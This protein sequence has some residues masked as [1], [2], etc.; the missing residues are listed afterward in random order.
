[1]K[2]FLVLLRSFLVGVRSGM[3]SGLGM[4][5]QICVGVNIDGLKGQPLET[6]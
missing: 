5:A 1:M 3:T 6:I 4:K 2:F